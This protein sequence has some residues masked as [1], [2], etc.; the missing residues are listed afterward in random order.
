[1]PLVHSLL[2]PNPSSFAAKAFADCWT[3]WKE[4]L[5]CLQPVIIK[6]KMRWK[7][8]SLRKSRQLLRTS[9]GRLNNSMSPHARFDRVVWRND[10]IC[11]GVHPRFNHK[12]ETTIEM[13]QGGVARQPLRD[14]CSETNAGRIETPSTDSMFRQ[15]LHEIEQP[16]ESK[17]EENLNYPVL[18]AK[19]TW[20]QLCNCHFNW[21]CTL[22]NQT[23]IIQSSSPYI[24]AWH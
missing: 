13:S 21:N 15:V 4:S 22:C 2:I 7:P 16:F 20:D 6:E 3:S 8:P 24:H 23:D 12:T 1:M 17:D 5:C 19:P 10:G 9:N 14:I 11:N 18:L